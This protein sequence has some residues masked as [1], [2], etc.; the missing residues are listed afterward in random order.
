V[1]A[2]RRDDIERARSTTPSERLQQAVQTMVDGIRLK[3]AALRDRFPGASDAEI[4]E[5]LERWLRR[6]EP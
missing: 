4:A 2:L 6:E 1:D 3:R 5:R